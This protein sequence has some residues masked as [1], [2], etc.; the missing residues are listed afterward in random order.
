MLLRDLARLIRPRSKLYAILFGFGA[1]NLC[2]PGI[3]I[4]KGKDGGVYAVGPRKIA[5]QVGEKQL[6][7]EV[8]G[9][10]TRVHDSVIRNRSGGIFSTSP[11]ISFICESRSSHFRIIAGI[12]MPGYRSIEPPWDLT[13]GHS[14][15]LS[16]V[17][18]Q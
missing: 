4:A 3:V 8:K 14:P 7:V 18:S 13:I 11:H 1:E 6:P 15:E 12:D 9:E 2:V 16:D 5:D 10:A 17:V